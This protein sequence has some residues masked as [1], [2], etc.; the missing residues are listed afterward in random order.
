MMLAL[1]GGTAVRSRPFPAWPPES[2]GA[3]AALDRVLASHRWTP[4]GWFTGATNC[5]EEFC[6]RFAEYHRAKHCLLTASGSA[7]LWTA[8]EALNVGAGDEVIVPAYTWIATAIAVLHVNAVPVLVDVDAE[9]GCIAPSAIEAAISSRTAAIIVVHLHGSAADMPAIMALAEAKGIA[10]LEDC[11]Q[12]VGARLDGRP[13][14]TFGALGAYSFSQEKL[15]SCGEGGA[16]VTNDA[17]LHEYGCRSRSDGARPRAGE[18]AVG[19]YELEDAPGFLGANYCASEFQA[20]VLLHEFEFLESR[21]GLRRDNARQL[22]EHLRQ[23]A[24]VAHVPSAPGTTDRAYFKYAIRLEAAAFSGAPLERIGRALTA[25]LG[26]KIEQT[27]CQP[28]HL[29]PLYCPLSKKRHALGADYQRAIDVRGLR[30]PVAEAH[31]DST[32]VL[33]HR[34]LLGGDDETR[35]I[36]EALAKVQRHA[37]EL[38]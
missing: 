8:L 21:N 34:A 16:V 6:T 3:R 19:E 4:R 14:G 15:L 31:Y 29:N 24:G 12:A 17:R 9:T 36:A 1:H 22:S 27:E 33:H 11:A 37:S 18:P 30:F 20:A 35:D 38:R 26:M 32:L 25:E 2:L 13:V 23:I 28:L 5:T 7:A 10:V